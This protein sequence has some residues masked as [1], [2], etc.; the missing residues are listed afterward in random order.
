MKD[1]YYESLR[2]RRPP[3]NLLRVTT[4]NLALIKTY[5]VTVPDYK[6]RSKELPFTLKKLSNRGN[7]DI[8]FLQELWHKKDMLVARKWASQNNYYSISNFL[9]KN[10]KLINKL[11]RRVPYRY[12]IDQDSTGLDILIHKKQ[13]KKIMKKTIQELQQ[14]SKLF[15][16]NDTAQ[17]QLRGGGAVEEAEDMGGID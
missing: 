8:I 1:R 5:S 10:K 17:K 14:L 11:G 4:Y 3:E 16:L 7:E 12:R 13:L 2:M 15:D 9:E 6:R